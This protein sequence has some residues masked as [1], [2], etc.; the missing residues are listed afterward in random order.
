[1]VIMRRPV[2]AVL[3]AV[4]LLAAFGLAGCGGYT[5]GAG[6][7]VVA[8][9]T[10]Q[11]LAAH[12]WLLNRSAST[13][14]STDTHPVTLVFT[15][16]GRFSGTA[17]CNAYGGSSTLEKGTL[18]IGGVGQTQGLC[19]PQAVDHAE[20]EY[21]A[22]LT[23]THTVDTSDRNRL[24]LKNG[25]NALS[26]DAHDAA[27]SLASDWRVVTIARENT[28]VSAL[29]GTDPILSFHSDGSLQL[30]TGCNTLHSSWVLDGTAL[31]VEP[32]RST[33]MACSEPAGV[34]EQETALGAA[35]TAAATV[36]LTPTQ[37]SILNKSGTILLVAQR[38][39]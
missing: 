34:M 11:Q 1:V 21:V 13:L 8:V 15:G 2:R 23:G 18:T 31:S 5:T 33:L 9:A 38:S 29:A 20:T 32:A 17:P 25:R 39:S 14:T 22:A 36:Q 28:L 35:L 24:V 19:L 26:Y 6:E 4:A 16:D 7:A 3:T 27:Q 37:L 12:E 10:P 30:T